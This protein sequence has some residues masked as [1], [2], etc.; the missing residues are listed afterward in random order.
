[1]NDK[2][3]LE[4][5]KKGH[6]AYEKIKGK[7]LHYV[8]LKNNVYHELV[9]KPQK[10]QFLHLCGLKY[11]NPKTKV[12]YSAKQFY[13]FVKTNRINLSGIIKDSMSDQKL[14]VLAQL[15]DLLTSNSKV[16]DSKTS[17]LKFTFYKAIR[18]R[19]R[20]FCLAL[21]AEDSRELDIYVPLSMLNLSV[22]TQGSSV[23]PGHSVHCVYLVED[24]TRKVEFLSKSPEFIE[25]EDNHIYPYAGVLQLEN[26]YPSSMTLELETHYTYESTVGK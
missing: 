5:L 25:Y 6:Q 16:I 9:F 22:N 3:T 19:R 23:P 8:Y 10:Q 15:H 13:D 1:M 21:V 20:V 2:K 17:F 12:P 14:L 4:L 26:A 24:K 11:I 18:S 7:E